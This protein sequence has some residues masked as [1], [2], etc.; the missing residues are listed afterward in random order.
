MSI[1]ILEGKNV[2]LICPFPIG[3]I[4][5]VFGWNHCYR[6]VT[7]HDDGPHTME[8]A[9][10]VTKQMILNW[11]TW[12]IVDKNHLTNTK[13]EAP[14]V[15]IVLYEPSTLRN[16]YIHISTARRAFKTGFAD[17][18]LQLVIRDVFT[19]IPTLLRISACMDEHNAPAKAL[20]KRIGF[21]FEGLLEDMILRGDVPKNIIYFGLT[22]RKYT[23]CNFLQEQEAPSLEVSLV[24][25]LIKT[26][27]EIPQVIP[28]D[29]VMKPQQ[30]TQL[31]AGL[32]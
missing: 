20:A 13:H 15:G 10:E 24:E 2:D 31:I 29:Q 25:S 30:E 4:G 14:L 32:Q 5:R 11:P 1:R 16:G 6:T 3:E 19:S 12:G 21:K 18:A 8:E 17:E 26:P 23:T 7:E 22:R 9:N 28:L 27:Q